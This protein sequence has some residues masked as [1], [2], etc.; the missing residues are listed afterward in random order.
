MAS[1]L[2]EERLQE[3]CGS[4]REQL[5][6]KGTKG[7][8]G[9]ARVFRQADFNG[10]KKLDKEEFE[11]ALSFNGLFL[12]KDQI[13]F[14]FSNFDRDGDGNINYDEFL[15]GIQLPLSK[16][17]L[18]VVQKAFKILDRDGSGIIEYS[19]VTGVYDAKQHPDVQEGKRTEEQVT[20]DFLKG[21]ERGTKDGKISWQEFQNYYEDLGSSIPS[22][23]YFV[24]MMESCWKIRREGA[25]A[26]ACSMGKLIGMVKTKSVQKTK[27]GQSVARTLQSIFKFFD[28]DESGHIKASEFKS[29]LVRLG[30]HTSDAEQAEFFSY[31]AGDDGKISITEFVDKLQLD[32]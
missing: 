23:E 20:T 28:E 4:I 12:K 11:E 19:D 29:A 6:R 3:I 8:S 24:S 27:T 17:R 1:S 25:A 14:L 7:L 10:N 26:E 21:F 30:I 18:E 16:A 5:F 32:D 22:D 13:S 31:F 15:H 2:K 9:V